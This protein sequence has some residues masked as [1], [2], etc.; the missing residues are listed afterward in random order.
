MKKAQGREECAV[1]IHHSSFIILPSAF[2]GKRYRARV[3]IFEPLNAKKL[4]R[5]AAGN[6]PGIDYTP[7]CSGNLTWWSHVSVQWRGGELVE[8]TNQGFN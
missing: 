3:P 1:R 4:E 8:E 5:P 2:P 7:Q 6:E